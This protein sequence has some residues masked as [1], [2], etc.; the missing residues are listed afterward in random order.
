MIKGLAREVETRMEDVG[1]KGS[2]VTL[3]VK[4]RKPNARPPPKFLG[5]GSC[6]NLSKSI[7]APHCTRDSSVFSKIG[8]QLFEQMNVLKDDVRGMGLVVSSLVFDDGDASTRPSAR[9]IENYFQKSVPSP[10][11]VSPKLQNG[12]RK[13]Q[14]DDSSVDII[15]IDSQDGFDVALPALSQIHMSQVDALPSPLRRQIKQKMKKE[16]SRQ[17]SHS[18]ATQT[19]PLQRTMQPE[20]S[21]NCGMEK[22]DS[23]VQFLFATTE[24]ATGQSSPSGSSRANAKNSEELFDHSIP[25]T[26]VLP[27]V[28][29]RDFYL[30]NVLPLSQ[31]L[32]ENSPSKAAV[33]KVA[34][35]FDQLIEA[36][37]LADA[38][39]LLRSIRNR[40]D[41]WSVDAF[42]SIR[43]EVD[44][45]V[46]HLTGLP[47]CTD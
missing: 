21:F 10:Q 45:R 11:G 1:V 39:I 18:S 26:I 22:T 3:K 41:S 16:R 8:V 42:E 9:K 17:R 6:F 23:E 40:G 36:Y 37:R 2:K 35:F 24:K 28:D 20:R 4:Q 13:T 47:I 19:H 14:N 30:H 43:R 27:Q 12:K 44:A 31:F 34:A 25:E 32:D 7:D 38:V 29:S 15:E 33:H 46:V 5:H